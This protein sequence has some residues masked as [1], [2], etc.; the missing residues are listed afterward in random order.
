MNEI[1]PVKVRGIEFGS[2][3]SKICIPLTAK[4][5][6]E[7][8]EQLLALEGEP[9]D[10]VEWRVDHFTD[11]GKQTGEIFRGGEVAVPVLISRL[12]ELLSKIRAAIGEERVI[13]FTFRTLEEGGERPL[14]PDAYETLV[15][16]AADT[17]KIDIADVEYRTGPGR[18]GRI[19]GYLHERGVKVLMSS[20]SFTETP[21]LDEMVS[22][23]L[24]MQVQ[25][26]DITKLAVMP[27]DRSEVARLL[28]A[29]CIMQ[30]TYA[31]TPFV[32]ISMG[33]LGVLSRVGGCLTGSAITFGTAG[34]A[35]APGQIP[36][37][38]LAKV[39]GILDIR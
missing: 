20:H 33:K 25:D 35:S 1:K 24:Q 15:C 28:T 37:E 16:A 38:D 5:E 8:D 17:G 7:L 11:S 31:D 39:L 22:R 29:A 18:L 6:E 34:K 2:G 30:E 32:A 10:M 27:A 36:A 19:T 14:T 26:A 12:G 13:L 9:Y 3:R 21:S 23:Y 4:D